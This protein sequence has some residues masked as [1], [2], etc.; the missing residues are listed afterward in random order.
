M[1]HHHTDTKPSF[2]YPTR[3]GAMT[4]RTSLVRAAVLAATAIVCGCNSLDAP[5]ENGLALQGLVTAPTVTGITDASEGLL[6]GMRGDASQLTQNFSI[7]GREGYNLDPGD[8]QLVQEYF[9]TLGDLAVWSNPYRTIKLADLILGG[10]NGV[11]SFTAPQKAGFRGFAMTV[12]AVELLNVVRNVDSSGAALDASAGAESALPP[13]VPAAQVYAYIGALLDSAQTALLAAGPSFAFN[14]GAGFTGFNTPATFLQFNRAIRV[15]AD[16]DVQNFGQALSDL[17]TSFV[18]T[19]QPLSY[20]VYFEFST[21]SGDVANPLFESTPRYYYAHPSLADSA[22]MKSDATPDDRLL[23]KVRQI[24][25][26]TR[27]GLTTQW[28]FQI[29]SGPGAPM[30]IIRNEELILLRAEANLGLGNNAA[31]IQDINFVRTTSGGLPP[32]SSPYVAVA[33]QP[34]TLLRELLYEKRYSL[35]WEPGS[36]SWLDARHYGTLAALPHDLPGFVVFPY[37]Y[38][39]LVECQ[40]R[41]NAPAGCKPPGGV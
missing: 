37:C 7:F 20:G 34:P 2:P 14:L 39:P 32:I 12:K 26:I 41:D 6:S 22:Q 23:T 27:A 15:R 4:T 10:V 28:T 35:M 24:P 17:S 9:Q 5:D 40:A 21:A 29:Y 8:L 31:A 11:A 25:P 1:R 16:V 33:G 3:R 38:I 13:I 19:S 30:A 18:S 36:S